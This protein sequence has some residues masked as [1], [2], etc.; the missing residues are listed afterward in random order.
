M[1]AVSQ[2]P[3]TL[4]VS[5]DWANMYMIIVAN[6]WLISLR[7]CD[8][9]PSGPHALRGLTSCRSFLT[10]SV[11][12]T[13][14]STVGNGSASIVGGA[15]LAE[16]ISNPDND[17]QSPLNSFNQKKYF[18][19]PHKPRRNHRNNYTWLCHRDDTYPARLYELSW[20]LTFIKVI[21]IFNLFS[22]SPSQCW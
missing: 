18:P 22:G 11:S 17:Y 15:K 21:I 14:F 2:S 5:R 10:P 12:I 6:S 7:I 19:K 20:P 3:G 13:R 8:D 16:K 4:P 9:T 1:L